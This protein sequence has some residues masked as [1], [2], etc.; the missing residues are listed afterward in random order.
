M[1]WE[2]AVRERRPDTHHG[3][4]LGEYLPELIERLAAGVEPQLDCPHASPE[5]LGAEHPLELMAQCHEPGELALEYGL[6]RG[7]ILRRLLEE[8]YP[9][10]GELA[11]LDAAIDQRVMHA[12]TLYV[13]TRAELAERERV[14]R[15]EAQRSLAQ[16]DT[17]LEV[18]PVGIA[19]LDR[20]LRYVRINEMLARVNGHPVAAHLGR[21]FREVVPSWVADH[22]EPLF[23]HVLHTHEP[24]LDHEYHSRRASD[25]RP[26]RSWLGHFYPVLTESGEALGLGCVLVDITA[27]KQEED[28]LRRTA[29]LREQLM[30][31]VGHDLRNPLHAITASAYL[32]ERQEGLGEAGLRAVER[33]RTSAGR[34][35]RLLGDILDFARS[36]L[37]NGL[38]VHF[39]RASLYDICHR[40]LEELRV[41]WPGRRLEL[42]LEGEAGGCWDADRLEQA[43]GNLVVNALQHGRADTPVRLAVREAGPELLLSVHNEGE[44]IPPA[45]R[46]SLFQPFRRGTT[47]KA[48][49]RGVGLGLYIVRQV[50]LAHGGD[51]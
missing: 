38:P 44:P 7:C 8:P 24:V 16:L 27:Q 2:Q 50:A 22:F 32:L 11:L 42:E 47:G 12:I 9:S 35:A 13:H 19:F 20:E 51:V 43:V 10:L 34:M 37:G 46:D 4:A 25:S 41:A 45:Q 23:L 5:P 14:A 1:D 28:E 15:A 6:L 33:I 21:T 3:P 31:M 30:A 29:A 17:L 49:T 26:P 36:S 40:A 39:E 48:A 18:A